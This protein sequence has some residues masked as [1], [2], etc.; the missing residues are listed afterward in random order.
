MLLWPTDNPRAT[1]RIWGTTMPETEGAHLSLI[2]DG[3]HMAFV[4]PPIDGK[5]GVKI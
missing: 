3:L 2:I 1:G 4:V 5:L